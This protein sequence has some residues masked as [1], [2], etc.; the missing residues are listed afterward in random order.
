MALLLALMAWLAEY[1]IGLMLVGAEMGRHMGKPVTSYGKLGAAAFGVC[2]LLSHHLL[3]PDGAAA[4]TLP[5]AVGRPC[6][7][8]HCDGCDRGLPGAV[9]SQGGRGSW[10]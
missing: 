7:W 3:S 10:M 2:T 5:R 6:R 8:C 1:S 9:G 4:S